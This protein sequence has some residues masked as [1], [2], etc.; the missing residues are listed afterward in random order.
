[1][2]SSYYAVLP[3]VALPPGGAREVGNKAWNLMRMAARQ[4]RVPAAFVLP[5]SWCRQYR[6]GR[7]D[8]SALQQALAAGMETLDA[9]TGLR[10]GCSR[11]PLLVSVRSGAPVSM[12]GMM[13]TVLNIGLNSTTVNGF[14]GMTG[15]PRLAWDCYRRLVESYAEV[16]FGQPAGAFDERIRQALSQADLE[17]DREFDFITLRQLTLG[18]LEQCREICA[19]PFPQ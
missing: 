2:N 17:T 7:L 3:G 12:P 14:I 18:M 19:T 9:S 8:E 16:V 15:N 1:M 5:T 13:E 4:I 6:A 11:R 10:F